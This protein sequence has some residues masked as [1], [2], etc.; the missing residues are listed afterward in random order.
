MRSLAKLGI[1]DELGESKFA[2]RMVDHESIVR[3]DAVER[4]PQRE[5]R[6]APPREPTATD[7]S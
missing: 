2:G 3:P 6:V 7:S 5:R 4:Q 1:I